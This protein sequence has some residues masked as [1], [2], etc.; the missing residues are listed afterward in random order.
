[1]QFTSFRSE[2]VILGNYNTFFQCYEND[3]IGSVGR[4]YEK[5][6]DRSENYINFG[7]LLSFILNFTETIH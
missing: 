3:F 7:P 2:K 5:S 1:M 4:R 6:S